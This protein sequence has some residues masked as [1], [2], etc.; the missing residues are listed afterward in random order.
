MSEV[1]SSE[2]FSSPVAHRQC[3]PALVSHQIADEENGLLILSMQ[4]SSNLH[5]TFSI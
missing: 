3:N 5:N 4:Y 2:V 1:F